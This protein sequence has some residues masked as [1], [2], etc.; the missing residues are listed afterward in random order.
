MKKQTRSYRIAF[1]MQPADAIRQRMKA[2]GMRYTQSDPILDAQG[3]P[4]H[5]G[6]PGEWNGTLSSKQL[7]T[8]DLPE[9]TVIEQLPQS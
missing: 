5:A 7:T 2:A 4:Q 6:Q 3:Q 9:E 1:P 8:L